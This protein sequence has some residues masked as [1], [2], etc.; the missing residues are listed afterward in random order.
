MVSQNERLSFEREYFKKSI[1][2][3]RQLAIDT[4]DSHLCKREYLRLL[5]ARVEYLEVVED[6]IRRLT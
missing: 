1:D 6:C 3:L 2:E 4:L 5:D